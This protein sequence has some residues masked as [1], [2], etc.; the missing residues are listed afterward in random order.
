MSAPLEL[1]DEA[2]ESLK[3]WESFASRSSRLTDIFMSRYLKL[4]ALEGGDYDL[5][6]ALKIP[7]VIATLKSK[8]EIAD[9]K[10]DPFY[11]LILR[12]P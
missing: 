7:E 5:L 12:R 2:E 6:L 8:P 9:Q 11:E 4:R 10:T 1:I 3:V